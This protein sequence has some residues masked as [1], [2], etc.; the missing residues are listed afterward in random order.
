MQDRPGII[1]YFYRYNHCPAASHGISIDNLM[2]KRIF[3]VLLSV[4]LG[5]GISAFS[6]AQPVNLHAVHYEINVLA[7]DFQYGT[8]TAS[9]TVSLTPLSE[10]VD[11]ASLEIIDLLVGDIWIEGQQITGFTQTDS[12]IIIPLPETLYPGDTLDVRIDYS[13]TPYHENWGGFHFAGEYAFNLGVGF[14]IIPHNLGK[15]W[16]PCIDNFTDRA[17]YDLFCSLPEGKMAVGGGI[18]SEITNN[19]NG[20]STYHWH[21]AQPVPTYL[22]SLAAGNYTCVSD[23]FSGINGKIPID[24]YVRPQE[25]NYVTGTYTHLKDILS[26]YE[27]CMGP[28]PWDRVGYTSTQL[29]AMEHATNIFV[30]YGTIN[31]GTSYESLMAHELSHMWMGDKVTCASAQDMWINE[32]WATFFAMYYALALYGDINTYKHDM[33][34]T[35]AKVLQYCHTSTGDGSYFPLNQ[36]PQEYTY[37]MSAYDKGSTVV[38]AL[39]FYLGD[40]LFFETLKAFI[41]EFAFNDAS[42]Y[43]MRDFMTGYTGIDM[44]GFFDNYVLH[45]GTPHYSVDSFNV[46]NRS[47]NQFAVDLYVKQK[48]KGPEFTGDGN[49]MEVWFMDQNWNKYTDTIHFNG[50]SGTSH[51]IVPFT[52]SVILVDPEEKMCDAT[53]DNYLTIRNTGNYSFDKTFFSLEVQA[54]Q[55]SAFIQVTHNWAPPDSLKNPD[56]GFRL[57][58]YRYWRIDGIFPENFQGRGKFF[59]SVGDVLDNTLILSSADT[60][61]ILYRSG[62]R[63]DWQEI[64]FEKIG[65]WSIGYIFVN[66]LQP[67]EYTLAVKETGVG[68]GEIIPEKHGKMS[69]FPNPSGDTFTIVT[70]SETVGQ[71]NIY[72]DSGLL[73]RS[74]DM[75][76]GKKRTKWFPGSLAAGTYYVSFCQPGNKSSETIK[77][78]YT[79]GL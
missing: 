24:V 40:S 16:F 18:L 54:L 70:E 35:H 1:F 46:T 12:L 33:R 4:C 60:V 31:G 73:V 62:A 13:G 67:G 61:I 42:S 19:G 10:P 66:N 6:V 68:T 57:S 38:Q 74:F 72:S 3:V 7:I 32:G 29:G 53:T 9:T 28:Y 48:R 65:P 76:C 44:T 49:I 37:G 51:K 50:L 39:R 69:V 63:G 20:T 11:E 26:V 34:A 8:I 14:E 78:I 71:V 5:A 17:T 77:I 27:D 23:T 30:P 21:L 75:P 36:I 52:P 79:P 59:Y 47:D 45:S 2:I 58:D 55:D 25:I 22:A 43:D 56:A 64:A 15:S 41:G